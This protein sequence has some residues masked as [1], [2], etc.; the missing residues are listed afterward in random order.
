MPLYRARVET[1]VEVV[2]FAENKK[3]AESLAEAN[4]KKW[5]LD[6][7]DDAF[8]PLLS[9][10]RLNQESDIPPD[11]RDRFTVDIPGT[12]PMQ[13][14]GKTS[15]EILTIERENRRQEL[16]SKRRDAQMG[17]IFDWAAKETADG[18]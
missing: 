5:T 11:W 14:E 9:V 17:N 13:L 18:V 6:T 15:S 1:I 10:V 3:Q 16:I 4:A 7:T 2:L 12:I 8:D